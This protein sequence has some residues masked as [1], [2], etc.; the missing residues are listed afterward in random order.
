MAGKLLQP[1]ELVDLIGNALQ[2]VEVHVEQL[3]PRQAAQRP[4]KSVQRVLLHNQ[5]LQV[6]QLLDLIGQVLQTVVG[7]MQEVQAPHAVDA[8]WDV[9]DVVVAEV[10][11]GEPAQLRQAVGKR[12][13]LVVGQTQDLQVGAASQF[14]GNFTQ[15]VPVSEEHSQLHEPSDLRREAEQLV[16]PHIEDHQ[17][18]QVPQ[19][20]WENGE[21]VQR[22][23][24]L[25]ELLELPQFVRHLL[26][27]SHG[28]AERAVAQMSGR[29][30]ADS[31][32]GR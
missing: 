30:F 2:L 23:V 13:N 16:P 3:Q 15:P 22:D 19:A 14:L 21:S 8:G 6:H 5:D 1:A 31:I 25:L 11:L 27:T 29:M 12:A 24:E 10:E 18:L 7:Q 9:L 17:V 32:D 26:Q 4:R 20:G 28:Q